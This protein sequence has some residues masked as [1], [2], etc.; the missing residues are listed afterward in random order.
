MVSRP[1]ASLPAAVWNTQSTARAFIPGLT[2]EMSMGRLSRSRTTGGIALAARTG[3]SGASFSN[4]HNTLDS[5]NTMDISHFPAFSRG[6]TTVKAG[7]R[8]HWRRGTP[9]ATGVSLSHP[10]SGFQPSRSHCRKAL[11]GWQGVK[12][13]EKRR[14]RHSGTNRRQLMESPVVLYHAPGTCKDFAVRKMYA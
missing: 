4:S 14:F 7:V 3:L 1:K 9:G 2:A 8:R 11:K 10:Q 12:L 13:T 6:A 5:S